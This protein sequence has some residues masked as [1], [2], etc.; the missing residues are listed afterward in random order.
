MTYNAVGKPIG[1]V[2]G[3]AKV[4]GAATYSA[5]IRLPSMIWGKA[6]RSPL[7]HA[8]IV[9]IDTS[10]AERLPGCWPC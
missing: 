7:P 9:R 10:A 2:E 6:L 8:R 3:P 1:R 5:D 4:T